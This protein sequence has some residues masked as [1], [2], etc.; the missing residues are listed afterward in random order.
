MDAWTAIRPALRHLPDAVEGLV[1][2][3]DR[4]GGVHA[5][6][7]GGTPPWDP[8]R[9]F[10]AIG[11]PG[12]SLWWRPEGG[13]ARVLAGPQ[14]GFPALAFEQINPALANVMRERA[15]ES[16]GDV[17]GQT[18]WDLYGGV[19]DTAR[20]LAAGG[21]RVWS[22]DADRNAIAWAES[23]PAA[24]GAP[25]IAYVA[26]RVEEV[27][28]RLPAPDAVIVNPPRT[29]LHERVA[30]RL[31]AWG[32]ERGPRARGVYLSCDAATLARDLKRMPSVRVRDISAFD[33]FPQT[34]HVE[35]LSALEGT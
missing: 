11:L 26:G 15:V 29:G 8:G 19:G 9:F 6:V 20:L 4:E 21:A 24:P 23:R 1:L 18:V 14:R 12:M 22:V 2:R 13:A 35:T 10:E 3:L 33:L 17:R 16:L 31:Q 5:I 7:L 27:L 25:P 32:A 30:A 28:H 34:A